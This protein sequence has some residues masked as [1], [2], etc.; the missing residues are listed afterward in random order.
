[1]LFLSFLLFVGMQAVR[2]A[3]F[4]SSRT[5][6]SF[7][8][9]LKL[10]LML[11]LQLIH[12]IVSCNCPLHGNQSVF[13]QQKLVDIVRLH[14]VQ[15]I[16]LVPCQLF[17]NVLLYSKVLSASQDANGQS[18]HTCDS[19]V[20]CALL[21]ALAS[22]SDCYAGVTADSKGAAATDTC[23]PWWQQV[24]ARSCSVAKR[25]A[26]QQPERFVPSPSVT[27]YPTPAPP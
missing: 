11:Q 6:P 17:S 3:N 7:L 15:Q 21:P 5:K 27:P 9:C 24:Q 14:L 8:L 26:C 19:V 1:M 18:H 12:R 22:A 13:K 16:D 20:F 2:Q 4:C 10:F 25:F 23:S